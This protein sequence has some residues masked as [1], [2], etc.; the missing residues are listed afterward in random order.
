MPK[1]THSIS[2]NGNGEPEFITFRVWLDS[3]PRSKT[4]D[5]IDDAMEF[6]RIN[7]DA[8][9]VDQI[10]TTIIANGKGMKG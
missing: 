6:F 10:V 5:N 8:V 1:R 3:L 9:R 7:D 4:F 2:V